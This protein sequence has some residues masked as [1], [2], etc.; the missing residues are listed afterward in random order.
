MGLFNKFGNLVFF[1]GNKLE[2]VVGYCMFYGDMVGGFVV[3]KDVYKII[4]FEFV[5]YCNS[6]LDKLVIFECVIICLFLVEL[7]LD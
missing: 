1:I 6:I 7:C 3:L 2:L 4:V 5:K